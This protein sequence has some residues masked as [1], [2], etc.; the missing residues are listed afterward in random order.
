MKKIVCLL[1]IVIL[2]SI[3]ACSNS[4]KLNG[5]RL[6]DFHNLFITEMPQEV[7]DN[8]L[9]RDM[10]L[11][12]EYA[13]LGDP[14]YVVY[15]T[16]SFED[17]SAFQS[18]LENINLDLAEKVQIDGDTH[19]IFQGSKEALIEYTDEEIHDGFNFAYEIVTIKKDTQ[20]VTYLY[21]YVWDYWPNDFL[22][23]KLEKI[24]M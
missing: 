19:Y 9:C 11:K 18:H 4:I 15:F 5:E 14:N 16:L 24:F 21:A 8:A 12:R 20:D 7:E 23:S 2:G 6:D 13:I 10:Y 3:S 17:H 22:I 1:L